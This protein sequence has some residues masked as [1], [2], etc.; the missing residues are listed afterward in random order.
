MSTP[1]ASFSL[2][3]FRQNIG[4]GSRVICNVCNTDPAPGKWKRAGIVTKV[5]LP[6]YEVKCKDGFIRTVTANEL[7]PWQQEEFNKDPYRQLYADCLHD[8]KKCV[9]IMPSW[10]PYEWD[11]NWDGTLRYDLMW[12]FPTSENYNQCLVNKTHPLAPHEFKNYVGFP[13]Y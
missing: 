8:P 7:V 10:R 1:P 5:A 2:Q 13:F 3:R 4:V 11:A 6:M 9:L 12:E